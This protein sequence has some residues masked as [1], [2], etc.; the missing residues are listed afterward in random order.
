MAPQSYPTSL[1]T[2]YAPILWLAGLLAMLCM[3]YCPKIG[4]KHYYTGPSTRLSGVRFSVTASTLR[5]TSRRHLR[6]LAASACMSSFQDMVAERSSPHH[7]QEHPGRIHPA[8]ATQSGTSPSRPSTNG[9]HPGSRQPL[10]DKTCLGWLLRSL[11]TRPKRLLVQV[12]AMGLS[13]TEWLPSGSGIKQKLRIPDER[14]ALDRARRSPTHPCGYAWDKEAS[15]RL[16]HRQVPAGRR[17]SLHS[18]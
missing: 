8:A 16:G 2:T 17:V 7:Q 5:S 3:W 1:Q 6:P 12:T 15:L 4:G 13:L 9:A 14:E 18:V 11:G 10:P